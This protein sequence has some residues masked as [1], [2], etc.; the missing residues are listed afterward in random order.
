[1]VILKKL[2]NFLSYFF[3]AVL[4]EFSWFL[5]TFFVVDN[6]PRKKL[7]IPRL[8]GYFLL[9]IFMYLFCSQLDYIMWSWKL[10][11]ESLTV[12]DR[13][14][15]FFYFISIFIVYSVYFF[16]SL[17]FIPLYYKVKYFLR[18]LLCLIFFVALTEHEWFWE[19]EVVWIMDT[20]RI[21]CWLFYFILYSAILFIEFGVNLEE[22][23]DDARL[24]HSRIA[25]ERGSTLLENEWYNLRNNTTVRSEEDKKMEWEMSSTTEFEEL[26]TQ[27]FGNPDDFGETPDKV[28]D[29]FEKHKQKMYPELLITTVA[30]RDLEDLEL[31]LADLMDSISLVQINDIEEDEIRRTLGRGYWVTTMLPWIR[32]HIGKVYALK[33]YV[34]DFWYLGIFKP[35]VVGNYSVYNPYFFKARKRTIKSLYLDK[36][37]YM[38]EYYL[39]WGLL[40]RFLWRFSI[41]TIL[42]NR[43][44]QQFKIKFYTQLIYLRKRRSGNYDFFKKDR[45]IKRKKFYK[46]L[47]TDFGTPITF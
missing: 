3:R 15:T 20:S 2:V 24:R 44:W 33:V 18:T 36:P 26:L 40:K 13:L 34:K 41:F 23:Y 11:E 8:L 35:K 14:N 38:R 19:V 28:W 22:E 31:E 7:F 32:K 42:K 12:D 25:Q 39:L 46:N 37:I 43:R 4:F 47:W 21:L 6:V 10:G 29:R 17:I 9:V 16:L 27:V 30:E 5:R 1:M 45:K